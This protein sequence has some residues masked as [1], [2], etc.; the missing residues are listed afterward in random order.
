MQFQLTQVELDKIAARKA[1][2]QYAESVTGIDWRLLAGI[3]YRENS[4]NIIPPTRVGGTWQFD[5]VLSPSRIKS[6]LDKYSTLNLSDKEL[7]IKD[8]GLSFKYG[9]VVAACFLR[10]HVPQVLDVRKKG[11]LS[12]DIIGNALYTYNGKAY[13]KD[14]RMSPYV[15]NNGDAQH[16]GL[17]INA[18]LPGPK[19]RIW[20]RKA[21]TRLGAFVVYRQ[22]KILYPRQI[23]Q[24][25]IEPIPEEVTKSEHQQVISL[26]DGKVID[27]TDKTG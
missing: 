9:A 23:K 27:L 25:D 21:D 12:D 22:L 26:I 18:S 14:W 8:G 7:I 17:K 3:W 20:I 15:Y 16:I 19:G 2:L 10:D 11:D 4:L 5:P 6:L 24:R 13:G 1:D